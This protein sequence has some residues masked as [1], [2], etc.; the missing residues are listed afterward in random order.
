VVALLPGSDPA[1]KDTYVV[2]SAH[3]DHVG[4][5]Q[6]NAK[7]D[8]IYNGA[9]DDASGTTAV[10]EVA[11]AFAALKQKPKRSLLFVTVSGEEKGLLGSAYF[12][13]HPPVAAEHIV[14]DINIDMIGRNNPDTV[15]A[16]GQEY[17]TLGTTVQEVARAH[18]DLKLKVAPDLWPEEQLFFRSDH[19]SFAQKGIPAIF[20]TTGLHD[21]YHQPSD[22]PATIDAD[23]L[24]RIARLVYHLGEAVASAT[25]APKWT[26]QGTSAMK[27]IGAA[28]R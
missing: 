25:T 12:A 9:D 4:V 28:V 5:G 6:P 17:T 13:E 15:V 26:E 10:L 19:F 22:E 7:G 16:I 21:D 20:F 8:S 18:A 2:F 11:Q 24:A 27:A 3:M 1:L 23:K 14:A